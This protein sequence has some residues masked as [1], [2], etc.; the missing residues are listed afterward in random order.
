[1]RT[2]ES[3]QEIA[4]KQ[5]LAPLS[6]RQTLDFLRS[7][8]VD[9]SF[10]VVRDVLQ[11][12]LKD[13]DLYA[14]QSRLDLTTVSQL[15]EHVTALMKGSSHKYG[16]TEN[17]DNLDLV[18]QP[19]YALDVGRGEDRTVPF[20]VTIDGLLPASG[21]ACL[22]VRVVCDRIAPRPFFYPRMMEIEEDG[23]GHPE[24]DLIRAYLAWVLQGILITAGMNKKSLEWIEVRGEEHDLYPLPQDGNW[25]NVLYEGLNIIDDYFVTSCLD[26]GMCN[27]EVSV[28]FGGRHHVG[29]WSRE[30]GIE[31][32]LFT[33]N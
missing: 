27:T 29:E 21:T 23:P 3:L 19:Y 13:F 16:Y 7:R 15:L 24:P 25:Y 18:L 14:L 32:R 1:M 31:F 2:L 28:A 9:F 26:F 11:A 12:K 22:L 30:I 20:E 33:M 6:L 17:V 8:D 10:K 5:T 4:L